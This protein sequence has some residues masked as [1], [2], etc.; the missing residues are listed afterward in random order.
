M[1]STASET[2]IGEWPLIE[3]HDTFQLWFSFAY[4]CG[5]CVK[6]VSLL[7]FFPLSCLTFPLPYCRP[8]AARQDAFYCG[9]IRIRPSKSGNAATNLSRQIF[10][11]PRQSVS[12]APIAGS[13]AAMNSNPAIQQEKRAS[14]PVPGG[15]NIRRFT[16]RCPSA[17]PAFSPKFPRFLLRIAGR[18]A[19]VVLQQHHSRFNCWKARRRDTMCRK[20]AFSQV[21][22]ADL[23]AGYFC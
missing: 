1:P 16:L 20:G 23:Q 8:Q 21:C 13:G 3:P 17:M 15:G 4:L 6:R 11:T 7:P 9:A 22:R 2:G 19:P 12:L 10:S 14:K 18:S 5:L